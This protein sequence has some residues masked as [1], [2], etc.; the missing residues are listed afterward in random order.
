MCSSDLETI[1]T[2]VTDGFAGANKALGWIKDAV[3]KAQKSIANA[4][5][6]IVSEQIQLLQLGDAGIQVAQYYTELPDKDILRAQLQKEIA[7]AKLRLENQ[8]ED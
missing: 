5:T 6:S 4:D 2:A 3:D 1:G 7:Q 8:K